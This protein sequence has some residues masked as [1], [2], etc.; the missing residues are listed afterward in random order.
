MHNIVDNTH[1]VLTVT[2]IYNEIEQLHKENKIDEVRKKCSKARK[3][4][5]TTTMFLKFLKH[6]VV[7]Y[8]DGAAWA[9]Q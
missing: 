6:G 5:K 1:D 7:M 8:R 3:Y 4:F 2:R 9:C